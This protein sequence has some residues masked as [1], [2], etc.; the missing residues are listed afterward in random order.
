VTVTGYPYSQITGF[1]NLAGLV[2]GDI[3]C[4]MRQI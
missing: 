4:V 3:S 1:F 2:F